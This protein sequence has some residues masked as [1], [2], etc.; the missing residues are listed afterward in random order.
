M[1]ARVFSFSL[2]ALSLVW[3]AISV[4]HPAQALT[5]K[6][7][8]HSGGLARGVP[9]NGMSPINERPGVVPWRM[10]AEVKQVKQKDKLV[11]QYTEAISKLDKTVVKL[12]G[13]MLPLEP[14]ERQRSFVLASNPPTCF[15]CLPAG[16]EGL[17]EIKT[18]TPVKLSFEPIVIEGRFAVLKDDP[19][20][21]Y[22]RLTE[23]TLS[24]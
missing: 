14:G 4:L 10:L 6:P 23:A 20:G 3:L 5:P 16:A 11:P 17:V 8:M 21:L 12:Q 13:Y 22:Y 7:E 2:F 24:K 9:L 19:L 15:Y 1:K 18:K